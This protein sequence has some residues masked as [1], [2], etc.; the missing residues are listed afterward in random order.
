MLNPL[1]AWRARQERKEL[2]ELT[3]MREEEE[4]RKRFCLDEAVRTANTDGE[5]WQ[6]TIYRA[7]RFYE[8]IY[9]PR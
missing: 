6:Q 4:F 3:E 1:K 9:G 8:W 5:D 7:E 2:R